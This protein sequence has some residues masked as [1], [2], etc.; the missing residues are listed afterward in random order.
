MANR[1]R[2]DVS[3]D[4]EGLAHRVAQWIT[5]LACATPG[6]FAIALSGG[7]T[8]KRLYQ[9]LAAPPLREAMPWERVHLFWGDDRFVA[10]DDPNSNYA[11]ARDAMI[12]QVPIPAENVH[13]IAFKGTAAD[14]AGAYETG[15]K[16]FYGADT[17]DPSRPLFDVM[18]LGMGPDGH[19]A[20]LFPGKPALDEMRRWVTEV[21]EPG[22]NPFVPRVTLTYP[23]LHSSKSTAFVAAGADKTAM[24]RRVLSGERDLPSAR[25]SPVGE[26]VWFVD[27]AARGEG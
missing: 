12:A 10:W 5:D 6:R 20:S 9:L 19:T 26:L 16:A 21:P 8:P 24:M 1:P 7:S 4:F 2:I 25:I 3:A 14:A 15:L 18:L 23:A 13:G 27:R 17:L 11:M 22:L